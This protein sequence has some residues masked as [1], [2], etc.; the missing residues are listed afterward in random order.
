VTVK[1]ATYGRDL[2]NGLYG[3]KDASA[4]FRIGRSKVAIADYNTKRMLVYID[5]DMV[6]DIPISM[7][8]GGYTTGSSGQTIHFWTVGGPHV[9]LGKSPTTR[10][11]SASYGIKD[12]NDPNYYDQVIKLTVHISYAGEYAH[13]ADWNIPAHGNTN[14][15]HGCINIGPA[16]IQWFYDTFGPGDV[17]DVR[18][19]PVAMNPRDGLGDWTIPWSQW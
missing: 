7:G 16:N 6:R 14:T 2:G 15:S 3:Q 19:S 10:M 13:L 18:N 5:G 4:S 17:V 12:P 1:A 11:T 8:K 9:V